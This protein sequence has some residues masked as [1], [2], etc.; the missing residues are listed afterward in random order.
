MTGPTTLGIA[1]LAICHLGTSSASA[2]TIDFGPGLPGAPVGFE[3]ILTNQLAGLGVEFSTPNPRGVSWYGPTH[4]FSDARYSIAAVEN[5][6]VA[7]QG[8]DPLRIDFSPFVT[9]F[10]V[11]G[12]DGGGDTDLMTVEAYDSTG[13]QVD[14]NSLSAV[15]DVPGNVLSVS[16][17]QIAYVIIQADPSI[18][19]AGLFFD[20][21]TFTPIPEPSA[22]VLTLL[23]VA[24][25][26]RSRR[27]EKLCVVS[28]E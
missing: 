3:T 18:A 8:V 11:R 5:G 10:S 26:A 9:D 28:T 1:F 14:F 27:H 21:I 13:G 17:R 7:P 2:V 22:L 24:F 6:G 16:A 25:T 20:D 15:F 23:G 4:P 12:F 19:P